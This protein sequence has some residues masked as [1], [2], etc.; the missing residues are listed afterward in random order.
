MKDHEILSD[1]TLINWAAKLITDPLWVEQWEA[2]RDRNFRFQELTRE[3]H[4]LRTTLAGGAASRKRRASVREAR[5]AHPSRKSDRPRL[6]GR[7][8]R[9]D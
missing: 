7:H 1:D 4:E 3:K 6:M 9:R 5:A 2:R 8:A